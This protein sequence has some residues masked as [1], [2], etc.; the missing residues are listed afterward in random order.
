MASCAF[1]TCFSEVGAAWRLDQMLTMRT[2]AT[3]ESRMISTTAWLPVSQRSCWERFSPGASLRLAWGAGAAAATPGPSAA[4]PSAP[5]TTCLGH[6]AAWM[7]RGDMRRW[8]PRAC[9]GG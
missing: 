6:L 8:P 4:L 1:A 7:Q 3:L 9:A 5:V 2:W